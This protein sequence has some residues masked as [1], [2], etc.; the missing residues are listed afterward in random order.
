MKLVVYADSPHRARPVSAWARTLLKLGPGE[1]VIPLVRDPSEM[2]ETAADLIRGEL[3]G[4]AGARVA[5][6]RGDGERPEEAIL[7]AASRLG[8]DVAVVSPAER[9]GL[10]RL[11][12]GSMVARVVGGAS[13]SVLVVKEGEIPPRRIL[14]CVSGSRRS[15]TN[16]RAAARLGVALDAEVTI[17]MVL[18]QLPVG[19]EREEEPH[20]SFLKSDH[21][22]AV[23][24]RTAE[25]LLRRLGARGGVRVRKGLVVDEILDEMEV[26][27]H[28]L[29]VL[30]TH[31]AEDYDPMYEDLTSELVGRTARSALVI[32]VPELPLGAGL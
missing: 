15:L 29:M 5:L 31:R 13:C 9:R 6:E 14:A 27:G 4:E 24:V 12:R 32:G 30:G 2:E 19:H 10:A 3:R 20:D 17:V 8:A 21:P 1:V 7:Q 23:H 11:L 25:E 26:P 22:L 16:V 28:D 18:S